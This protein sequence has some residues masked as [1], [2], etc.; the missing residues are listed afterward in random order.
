M[1]T[2]QNALT[3]K[4]S[5]LSI[6]IFLMMA[7]QISSA[8]PLM[9]HAFPGVNEAGVQTLATIPNFG[10][11]AGL[12][13]SP[14]LV[15]M[16]GE[17]AT[18]LTGL[19]ITL[20][21]GTFPMYSDNYTSILISRFL[22]G[23]GIGLFNSLAVSLIPQFYKNDEN[24]L[25]K[26]IGYQNVMGSVGA[27]IASFLVSYLVTISWHAAFAIY[28]LVIPALILF[29]LFV[30]LPSKNAN[31]N[32][33]ETKQNKK[34]RIN[35]KVILIS[36]LMFLIFAFYMPFSFNL[37]SLII[38][39]GL[40]NASTSALITGISTLV[41]IPIGACF[42]LIFKKIH[43]KIFPLGL[44]LVAIG[45]L[46]IALASNL[47]ILFIAVIILGFGFGIAVPYMYNWLDWAA[48]EGSVNL[49]TTI[50]LVLV[51]IGCFLSPTIVDTM[52]KL[53]NLNTP[54][55]IMLLSTGVFLIL[56]CYAL[57]HYL[58]VHRYQTKTN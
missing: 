39:K 29:A 34:Q 51:N 50:V 15:R 53:L 40:G 2:K 10:I 56:T 27:A 30:P 38:S 36:A 55:G 54:E 35:G 47:V 57:G 26:M 19:I 45:M 6:S 8:L 41:S 7:P 16:L 17:K 33:D 28:F 25:A 18:I 14:F 31:L 32:T 24:E 13:L 44:A 37:P 58:R 9:Y 12:F 21:T 42:G 23:T 48:P 4:I 20:V 49:A 46:L 22:I 1:K 52:A 11:V 3:F 5:L 43:D